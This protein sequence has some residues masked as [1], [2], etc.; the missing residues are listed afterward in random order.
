MSFSQSCPD[1]GA[2]LGLFTAHRLKHH[3]YG[4]RE[5]GPKC[6]SCISGGLAHTELFT[7]QASAFQRAGLSHIPSL[8]GH[9]RRHALCLAMP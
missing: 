5:M 8:V 4:P 2:I 3:R 7:L 1:G 6:S 9:K